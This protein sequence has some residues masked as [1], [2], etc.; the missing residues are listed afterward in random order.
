MISGPLPHLHVE[1]R[2]PAVGSRRRHAHRASGLDLVRVLT[3][4]VT[5]L[6][7]ADTMAIGMCLPALGRDPIARAIPT[8]EVALVITA[9]LAAVAALLVTGGRLADLLGRRAVLAAGLVLFASG[10]LAMVAGPAWPAVLAGRLVQGVGTALMLPAALGLLL[11][12]VPNN[13]R[14]GAVALW[15]SA[16]A[17][18][19]MIMHAAGGQLLAAHGWRVLYLPLGLS[20]VALLLLVAVLPRSQVRQRDRPDVLALAASAGA[21]TA[22]MLLVTYSSRWGWTSPAT[23]GA[24]MAAAGGFWLVLARSRRRA[25]GTIDRTL[26]RC[27]GFGWGL[28]ASLLYGMLAFPFLTLAPMVLRERGMGVAEVG[29]ALAPLSAAVIASSLLASRL[30]RRLG[31][32]GGL[33]VGAYAAT[34]GL[35][36]LL[37]TSH[38]PVGA[39]IGLLVAGTGFGLINTT[40]TISGTVT[41]DPAHYAAAVGAITTAR[42]LGA[43]VGP[44]IA[45]AYLDCTAQPPGV[46][47]PDVLIGCAAVAILLAVSALVRAIWRPTGGGTRGAPAEALPAPVSVS[48]TP[49]DLERLR[50]TLQ[51]QRARLDTIA[52]TA[53]QEL[54]A[55]TSTPRARP[56]TP[57][58]WT[59]TTPSPEG[60]P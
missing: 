1:D 16:T 39:L 60:S 46:G 28:L 10:A 40:A 41:V 6:V 53:E 59:T 42:M 45:L 5:A 38:A 29:L 19:G 51:R 50:E 21:T 36:T 27:R 31:T 18:G 20:A 17:T 48:A 49:E 47:Y 2:A 55:L 37:A 56:A 58:L 52:R 8:G 13:Q 25:G 43:A 57:F 7:M 14:R 22:L 3:V 23:L 4:A 30:T 11:G 34:A 44:A 15:G 9:N 26:W 32:S 24:A 54:T 12:H 33:Y 35:L